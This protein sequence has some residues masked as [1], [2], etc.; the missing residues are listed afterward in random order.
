MFARFRLKKIRW[1]ELFVFWHQ[2]LLFST[3]QYKKP[4]SSLQVL[5]CD[6]FSVS[7]CWRYIFKGFVWEMV[8]KFLHGASSHLILWKEYQDEKTTFHSF[9]LNEFHSFNG[10]KCWSCYITIRKHCCILV[11][12]GSPYQRCILKLRILENF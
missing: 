12:S 7:P 4:I 1:I 2:P 11:L 5:L 9:I 3:Y 8:Y 10:S 6:I